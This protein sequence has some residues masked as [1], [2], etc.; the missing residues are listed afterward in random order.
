MEILAINI[1]LSAQLPL[2][3]PGCKRSRL[4]RTQIDT[5]RRNDPH[6]GPD[7]FRGGNGNRDRR[8]HAHGLVCRSTDLNLNLKGTDACWNSRPG[9]DAP[10]HRPL[11]YQSVDHLTPCSATSRQ[12]RRHRR[13]RRALPTPRCV[14]PTHQSRRA[15][16]RGSLALATAHRLAAPL[17]CSRAAQGE[18]RQ[19]PSAV[20]SYARDSADGLPQHVQQ[21]QC[22]GRAGRG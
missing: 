4:H 12:D 13:S 21:H 1:G 10:H 2:C 17:T 16:F 9:K 20:S 6:D 3:A 14:L 22:R 5:L 15:E 8:G 18:Q 19:R 7:S 11:Q